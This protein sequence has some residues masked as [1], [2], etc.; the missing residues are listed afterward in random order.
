MGFT[1]KE[2][3]LNY[4]NHKSVNKLGIEQVLSKNEYRAKKSIG[5][6]SKKYYFYQTK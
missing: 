2:A 5:K 3:K 6:N 1:I 4:L